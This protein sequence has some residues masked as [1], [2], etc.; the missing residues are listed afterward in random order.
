MMKK[1]LSAFLVL[2]LTLSFGI[3]PSNTNA[4]GA[5]FSIVDVDIDNTDMSDV[6]RLYVERSQTINIRVELQSNNDWPHTGEGADILWNTDYVEDNVRIKAEIS[7]Y[8]YGDIEDVSEIFKVKYSD[9]IVKHLRLTI[10]NDIDSNKGYKLKIRAYNNDYEAQDEYTLSVNSQRHLINI[11]DVIFTPGLNL[12]QD[13]PLFTS[14]RL[15]NFGDKKEENIKIM[16]TVP[17]LGK[18]GVTYIDE[19]VTVEESDSDEETS[20][21]SDAIYVDLRGA[22]PGTYDLIVK[23]EYNRGHSELTR[24]YQLTINGASIKTQEDLIVDAAEKT[25]STSAGQG[26]VYKIDIANMGNTVRSFTA[27]VTGLDWGS[28]RV[29]PTITIVQPGSTGELFV[30]VSS[31]EG[32]AGQKTFTVNVK[33]GSNVAKQISFQTNIVEARNNWDNMLG[34]LQ[35]GFI[36]LLVILVILGIILAATKMGKKNSDEPLG[37]SYY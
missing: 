15:E 3:L 18:T 4:Q 19:L 30:Y 1:L 11:M 20:E 26:V 33:E 31:N 6:N 37:E 5:P 14:V 17:Q 34:G 13:Q 29:D 12:N 28:Y 8:E 27:E 23:V 2:V 36:I 7:G 10:P 32:V 25:K 9:R 16:V 22:Q 21:S 35:I 24:N